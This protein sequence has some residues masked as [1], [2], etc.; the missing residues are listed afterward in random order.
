MRRL[1]IRMGRISI[2][3]LKYFYTANYVLGKLPPGYFLGLDLGTR[4]FGAAC[5]TP[6]LLESFPVR[7]K[8]SSLDLPDEVRHLNDFVLRLARKRGPP[9]GIIYGL[10]GSDVADPQQT[11][12]A[13]EELVE[14]LDMH[15]LGNFRECLFAPV[16]EWRSTIIST[17]L[18]QQITN[19][20]VVSKTVEPREQ[21]VDNFSAK[22]ILDTFLEY[23]KE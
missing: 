14:G 11:D 19:S 16:N 5:S 12:G 13:I 8:I 15:L 4:F 18:L 23:L 10:S 6:D 20:L 22:V 9:I 3:R 2:E 17:A 1:L 21:D 7:A